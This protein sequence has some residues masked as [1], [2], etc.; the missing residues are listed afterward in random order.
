MSGTG[1][2]ARI[3]KA[4]AE[5]DRVIGDME[6]PDDGQRKRPR[7]VYLP[8]DAATH[9]PE[10]L[11]T[12]A[13]AAGALWEE[14]QDWL[15]GSHAETAAYVAD[16]MALPAAMQASSINLKRRKASQT[17]RV[18][19]ARATADRVQANYARRGSPKLTEAAEREMCKD[20]AVS[21]A[22]LRRALRQSQT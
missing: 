3:R 21:R 4:A 1:T 18:Q 14:G 13:D 16:G 11:K 17:P 5:V 22:V 19:A 6:R 7:M 2:P 20:L 8:D 9:A 12:L 10:A 15:Y